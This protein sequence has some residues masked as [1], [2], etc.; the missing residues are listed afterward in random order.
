M[1]YTYHD[2]KTKTVAQLREIAAGL[3]SEAV[4]G[5]TQLN[6]DH[7]LTVLCHALKIDP[8]E[9]HQVVL[10]NKNRIKSNI[11]KLKTLRDEAIANRDHAKLEHI[12]GQISSLKKRLRRSI[13]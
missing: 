13:T 4:K 10:Q 5:Y 7:L 2:L 6:K 9:H 8:H 3:P 1:T 12:R 11:Q